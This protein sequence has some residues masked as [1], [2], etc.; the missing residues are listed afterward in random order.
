MNKLSKPEIFTPKYKTKKRLSRI[1]VDLLT[2]DEIQSQANLK[3][4][5]YTKM[6]DKLTLAKHGQTE[7]KL[8]KFLRKGENIQESI[9]KNFFSNDDNLMQNLL[10]RKHVEDK[11]QEEYAKNKRAHN[12]EYNGELRNVLS[13]NYKRF[14][15]PKVLTSP[16]RYLT[17]FESYTHINQ[18][19]IDLGLILNNMKKNYIENNKNKPKSLI[20]LNKKNLAK[21]KSTDY[22]K[23]NNIMKILSSGRIINTLPTLNSK[24]KFK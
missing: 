14:Q 8:Y 17:R 22:S 5:D 3:R 13:K 4:E 6:I 18:K 21:S 16:D 2:S 23:M 12:A 20:S 1:G 24:S 19:D 15:Y 9:I 11:A 10:K 7:N